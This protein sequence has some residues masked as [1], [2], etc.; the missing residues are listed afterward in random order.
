M[1]R[2]GKLPSGQYPECLGHDVATDS[3]VKRGGSDP[4]TMQSFH[5]MCSATGVTDAHHGLCIRS[6]TCPYVDPHHFQFRRFFPLILVQQVAWLSPKHAEH[7]PFLPP[8]PYPVSGQRRGV[9]PANRAEILRFRLIPGR[10]G[11]LHQL[12]EKRELFVIR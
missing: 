11:C 1:D 10:T 7:R 3:I 9:E 6:V 12:L 8:N 2:S 4:V 5:A